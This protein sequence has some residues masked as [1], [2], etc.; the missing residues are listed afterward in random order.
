HMVSKNLIEKKSLMP[1]ELQ[2]ETINEIATTA[3]ELEILSTN[4]LNWIKYNKEGKKLNVTAINIH[5]LVEEIFGVFRLIVKRK[6]ITLVNNVTNEDEIFQYAEPLKIVIYNLLVNAI[7]FSENGSI[8]VDCKKSTTGVLITVT[9]EGV[10]MTAEQI[11]NVLN[12]EYVIS[13]ENVDKKKGNGLGYLIIK[14]LLK[15]MGASIQ[16]QSE[17]MSGTKVQVNIPARKLQ[18]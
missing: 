17:K 6:N 8:A 18:Q 4:I 13:S 9:D 3:N 1:E 5:N 10:G 14:D 16:I 15:I 2:A 12:D 7:N 11:H